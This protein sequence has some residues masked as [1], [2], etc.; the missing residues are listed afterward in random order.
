MPPRRESIW[1]LA[2]TDWAKQ[3]WP[4]KVHHS[5]DVTLTFTRRGIEVSGWFDSNVGIGPT[6][7]IPWAE[8]DQR[9]AE[10]NQPST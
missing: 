5:D 1:S 6:T 2:D 3:G 10:V 9:R 4:S 7:L 8:I